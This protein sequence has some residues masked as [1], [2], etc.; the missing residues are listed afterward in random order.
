[1][2]IKAISGEIEK[3]KADSI[4]LGCFEGEAPSGTLAIVDKALRGGLT[5]LINQKEIK[6]KL[7]EVTIIHSL[8]RLPAAR[9]VLLGLGKRDSLTKDKI[10]GA[11]AAAL[12]T[13]RQK[14]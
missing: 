11:T 9:I 3:T 2:E 4:M 10:R 1:M 5:H 6:G 7:D 14:H 13:M 12:K 8:G